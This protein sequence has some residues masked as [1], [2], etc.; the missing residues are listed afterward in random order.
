MGQDEGVCRVLD[1]WFVAG[2]CGGRRG[3]KN[4]LAASDCFWRK[5]RCAATASLYV[6]NQHLR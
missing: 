4:S 1:D 3:L 5:S 2:G 6:C